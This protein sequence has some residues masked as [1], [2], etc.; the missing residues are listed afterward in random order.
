MPTILSI[1]REPTLLATREGVLNTAGFRVHSVTT[2]SRQLGE[3]VRQGADLAILCHSVQGRPLKR[4]VSLL[5]HAGI[6]Y[7]CM[8]RSA[9]YEPEKFISDVLVRTKI[10]PTAETHRSLREACE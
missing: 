1:G 2:D 10:G 3:L 4:I 9:T 5:K 7:V 8:D 6:S